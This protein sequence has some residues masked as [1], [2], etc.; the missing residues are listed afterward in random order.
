MLLMFHGAGKDLFTLVMFV[1]T[2]EIRVSFEHAKWFLSQYKCQ[3]K[4]CSSQLNSK[5]HTL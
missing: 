1:T 3:Y 5:G 2:A 4:C